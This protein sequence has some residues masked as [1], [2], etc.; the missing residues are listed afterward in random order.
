MIYINQVFF[1]LEYEYF[2]HILTLF[3]TCMYICII[4]VCYSV[5]VYLTK[6]NEID[7]YLNYLN[8]RKKNR[9]LMIPTVLLKWIFLFV[10]LNKCGGNGLFVL[11]Y[12]FFFYSSLYSS[13]YVC[14]Y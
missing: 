10:N 6:N 7:G 2:N 14:F 12:V 1:V 5:V 3:V 8:Y 13:I 4:R 9:L 11:W